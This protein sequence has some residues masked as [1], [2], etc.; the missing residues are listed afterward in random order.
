KLSYLSWGEPSKDVFVWLPGSL[1]SAYDF[2]PF[3]DLLTQAGYF[4]ISVDHYGHGFTPIPQRDVD[5]SDF[6]LDLSELLKSLHIEKAIVGGLSRGGY[7]ATNFYK[8]FPDQVKALV[9]E[10]GGTV[11]FRIPF[12]KMTAEDLQ[13]RLQEVE[14]ADDIKELFLGVY[15][16]EFQV[17]ANL[18]DKESA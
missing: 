2:E 15:D 14:P 7:L 3:A 16:S 5:F 17:Y 1:L 18:Y 10:D 4:V 6:A 8:E 13:Q 9:L 11:S 12:F